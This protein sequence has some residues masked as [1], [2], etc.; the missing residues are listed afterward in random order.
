MTS[1]S[2]DSVPNAPPGEAAAPKILLEN[3]VVWA[4]RPDMQV[5]LTLWQAETSA[6]TVFRPLQTR[7]YTA[8]KAVTYLT[9]FSR[10]RW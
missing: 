3:P 10:D 9:L 1:L 4:G 7:N 6:R 5:P 2:Q 8:R